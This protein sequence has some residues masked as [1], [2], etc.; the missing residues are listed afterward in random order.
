MGTTSFISSL[1]RDTCE[2]SLLYNGHRY[3]DHRIAMLNDDVPN[4]SL[5]STLM[6]M[7]IP[8]LMIIIIIKTVTIMTIE[9]VHMRGLRTSGPAKEGNV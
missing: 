7:M 2:S 6:I 9:P 8:M 3:H 4:C 1:N 5:N